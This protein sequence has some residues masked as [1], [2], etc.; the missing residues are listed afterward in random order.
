MMDQQSFRRYAAIYGGD[1]SRWPVELLPA[2]AETLKQNPDM[3][4]ILQAE[5]SLDQALAALPAPTAP[6]QLRI[7]LLNIP[8]R[9]TTGFGL[10]WLRPSHLVP[11]M[12]LCSM[13][14]LFICVNDP[15]Q[16]MQDAHTQSAWIFAP[17]ETTN[18]F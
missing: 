6:A 5:F 8:Q 1:L 3:E 16:Q 14:G 18:I 17:E 10:S 2:V 11:A 15:I 7:R 12:V 9:Y 13:L 4:Q